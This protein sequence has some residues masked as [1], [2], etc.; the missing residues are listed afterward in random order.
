MRH[1]CNVRGRRKTRFPSLSCCFQV[2][3][4]QVA[5]FSCNIRFFKLFGSRLQLER[6]SAFV[7]VVLLYLMGFALWFALGLAVCSTMQIHE[8]SIMRFD[9]TRQPT[10]ETE[11]SYSCGIPFFVS[12]S[13]ANE[14]Q[15]TTDKSCRSMWKPTH[16]KRTCDMFFHLSVRGGG[17]SN[18]NLHRHHHV[19]RLPL[20][21]LCFCVPDADCRHQLP[22]A[23]RPK[24]VCSRRSLTWFDV[25]QAGG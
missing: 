3:L 1:A 8:R 11:G 9:G 22:W 14:F 16:E 21:E 4:C 2:G 7:S 19:R 15:C 10:K 18:G 24:F 12:R 20:H 17:K 25:S 5:V 23:W 13:A 6:Y